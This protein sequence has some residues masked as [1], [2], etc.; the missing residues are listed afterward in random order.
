[1]PD[2]TPALRSLRE[3]CKR[4]LDQL[5]PSQEQRIV[6]V[7]ALRMMCNDKMGSDAA[8]NAT[9]AQIHALEVAEARVSGLLAVGVFSRVMLKAE[10]AA[11]A[12]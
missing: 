6:R 12:I 5:D 10:A 7:T 1:M 3:A 8:A 4:L 2:A 9:A 11:L